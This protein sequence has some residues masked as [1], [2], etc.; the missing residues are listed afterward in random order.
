MQLGYPDLLPRVDA[1]IAS[2]G[3]QALRHGDGVNSHSILSVMAG[4]W[5]TRL[6]MT[7]ALDMAGWPRWLT[8]TVWHLS[9][10]TVRSAE[11]EAIAATAFVRDFA[12]S[13]QVERDLDAAKDQLF[14]AALGGP[15]YSALKALHRIR[16]MGGAGVARHISFI[17]DVMAALKMRAAGGDVRD[18]IAPLSRIHESIVGDDFDTKFYAAFAAHWA[19]AGSEHLPQRCQPDVPRQVLDAVASAFHPRPSDHR[20]DWVAVRQAQRGMLISAIQAS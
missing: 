5:A 8:I 15:Q 19:F 20:K 2:G 1:A 12:V 11:R 7:E 6:P 10:Q 14:I 13:M 17:E 3:F 9:A 4:K 16:L 18:R